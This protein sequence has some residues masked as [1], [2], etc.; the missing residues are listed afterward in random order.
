MPLLN[1]M[2]LSTFRGNKKYLIWSFLLNYLQLRNMNVRE[3]MVSFVKYKFRQLEKV[4]LFS[5]IHIGKI[6]NEF[7][8]IPIVV[9]D[10]RTG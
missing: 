4:K 7:L 5:F 6:N 9:K 10:Q 1:G 8:G 2:I 3:L